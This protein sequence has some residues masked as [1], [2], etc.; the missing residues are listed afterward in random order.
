MTNV[1]CP[2]CGKVLR[3]ADDLL[4][5]SVQCP[6]CAHRFGAPPPPSSPS[7][8]LVLETLDEDRG[9][10]ELPGLPV[11]G[12]PPPPRPFKAVLV[13]TNLDAPYPDRP[14]GGLTCALCGARGL[15]SAARCPVCDA[16]LRDAAQ[17]TV[18]RRRDYEP[19][20]G[21]WIA[22][23]GT[24]SVILGA[25]GLCGALFPPF[26]LASLLGLI[27]GVCAIVMGRAD[28]E[29]MDRN[30]MDPDGRGHTTNGKAQGGLGIVLGLIGAF[31][32]CM[33]LMFSM[34]ASGW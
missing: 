6:A 25:P 23:L 33:N 32:G 2:Q 13:S 22:T 12:V 18:M 11:R 20:R 10:H 29:Q 17:P 15:P 30:I 27:L 14:T 19:H 4:G 28:L 34:M 1:D 24:F 5:A 31:L 16:S 3:L 21:H 9:T 26:A 7:A 8:P